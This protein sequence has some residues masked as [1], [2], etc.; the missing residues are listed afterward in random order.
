MRLFNKLKKLMLGWSKSLPKH[1]TG[2]YQREDSSAD[3]MAPEFTLFT[4]ALNYW[5]GYQEGL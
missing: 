3:R 1:P 5:F 2:F 4:T